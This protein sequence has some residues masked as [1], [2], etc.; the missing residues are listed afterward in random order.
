M[1]GSMSEAPTSNALTP[2]SGSEG[3]IEENAPAN[4][5]AMLQSILG[6]WAKSFG[7]A[8]VV[9]RGN[10][11]VGRGAAGVRRKGAADRVTLE[12]RF[13]LGSCGKAMTAT[14]VATLVEEGRLSWTDTLGGI[15]A[16]TIKD[17]HPAWEKVTLPKLLAHC[18]GMR[19]VA[20]RALR[21]RLGPPENLP[22]QRLEIARYTLARA[23]DSAPR[24]KFTWLGYSNIGYTIAGAVLEHVT[25]YSWEDLMRDRLFLPLGI[26]TGGFG[27]P[28]AASKTDQPW[29][30]TW[31]T[32]KPLAPGNSAAELPLFY[33]PAGLVHMAVEDWAKFVAL[34]LRGDPA[35]PHRQS[36]VLDPATFAEL[37]TNATA[38]T[39]S[40]GWLI[41]RADW[42][43]GARP[44]DTGRCLWHGGSNGKW[45]CAVT[46]APEIDFAVLVAGNR[47]PDIPVWWKGRQAIKALIR[48]FAS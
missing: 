5:D 14:L 37:H 28:G 10:C 24:A 44:G 6:R 48:T 39:Y 29:G 11:I 9:L 15:F 42:A 20:S 17:I 41:T 31:I 21:S 1:G 27:P 32:G 22:N 3:K 43:K 12:D 40:A 4:V 35:N 7:M 23:P 38:G 25:G 30:H 18:A 34:H 16:G 2:A 19:L 36:A 13:H 33:G 26:T 46:I 47:G 45:A 8:A